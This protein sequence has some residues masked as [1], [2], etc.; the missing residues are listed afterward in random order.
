MRT[1]ASSGSASTCSSSCCSSAIDSATNCV[2]HAALPAAPLPPRRICVDPL[3]VRR[4]AL[5]QVALEQ[6]LHLREAVEAERVGEADH[7]RRLDGVGLRDRGDGAEGEVVRLLEREARQA[8]QLRRELRVDRGDRL[9]QLVERGGAWG[10]RSRTIGENQTVRTKVLVCRNTR[11]Y[12][13]FCPARF[14]RMST[15]SAARRLPAPAD[16]RRLLLAAGD[17]A[18]LA[19]ARRP[20]SVPRARGHGLDAVRARLQPD[21]RH[22]RPAVV[23]P[24]RLLR[25]GA[26]AFG[27]LQQRVS[28]T[29]GSTSAAR[30]LVTALLGAL[31]GA[32]VAHKRGIYFALLTIA[33]GQVFW[34][35]SVKWHSVT[36]GEDGLQNIARPLLPLG[37]ATVDLRGNQALFYFCLG[38]VRG[39]LV[40][41]WRLV[42]SPFGRV[43]AAIR[44]NELRAAFVGY[45][46]W[47]YKWLSFTIA[48][49]VRRPRRRDVRDGAAVGLSE[50]DEPALVGLRRHDGADRRRP[51][52]LL[53]AGDRRA[54]LHPRARRARRRRP[55]PGCSGTACCSSSMVLWQPE[56]IAG[57][58]QAWRRRARGA[59][60]APVAAPR[61]RA[62]AQGALH[63]PL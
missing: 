21:A 61:R 41:L 56:G 15:A 54:L 63:G 16:A 51:G 17:D 8:L 30:S 58:W 32:C 13:S 62:A 23:R 38:A 48:S 47:L 9:L 35:V 20:V 46:V 31:V 27:L 1:A 42:H 53:G 55:R 14:P 44:Q 3:A 24:R 39:R 4:R 37:V 50:R 22:H 29:S 18:A 26:Y 36:G 28:P 6:L 25:R 52:E 12:I 2:Q 40:V 33:F 10:H 57:I 45:H 7:R 60:S 49:A 11:T 34:F 59:R 5:D 43:L 19:R